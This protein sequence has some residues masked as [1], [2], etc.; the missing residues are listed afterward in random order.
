MTGQSISS[1]A[2]PNRAFHRIL[3][4]IKQLPSPSEVC[5]AVTRATEAQHTTLADL[6]SLVESDIALSGRL[7]QV[8]NSSFFGVR[9]QVTSVRRAISLLGF[10]TV[11]TLALGFFF[12]EEFGK[13]RLPGLPYPDL[14]RFALASSVLAESI[15]HE[16]DPDRKAEAAC[17]GLLHESGVI[18]MAMTFGSH[19][20]QMLKLGTSTSAELAG[21]EQRTFGLSHPLAGQLL[22]ESWR[23]GPDLASAVANHHRL[24]GE[25]ELPASC[26]PLW[27]ILLLANSL[28]LPLL[29]PQPVVVAEA[30]AGEA[31]PG[32]QEQTGL[33]QRLF[34]WPIEKVD[35]VMKMAARMYHERLAILGQHPASADETD[36]APADGL[37]D[38]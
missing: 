7:M 11:R 35:Q 8:A 24:E 32:L 33:A 6:Q 36:V 1:V 16:Q 23:L 20:R 27:K 3:G 4:S 38:P 13:L 17:L 26:V 2:A 14:P 21:L 37:C 10:A 9:E 15:A 5:L 25:S 19:Y 22:F 34:A 18:I 28:A 12:N 29:R 31:A 30:P